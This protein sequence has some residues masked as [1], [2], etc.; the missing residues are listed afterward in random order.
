MGQDRVNA[1]SPQ[2]MAKSSW[3]LIVEKMIT[4]LPN[5]KC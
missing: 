4:N 3:L 2:V 1:G 5:R